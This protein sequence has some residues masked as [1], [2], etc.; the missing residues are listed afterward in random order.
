MG[1]EHIGISNPT[2]TRSKAARFGSLS[3]TPN[4]V[5]DANLSHSAEEHDV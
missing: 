1:Y 5:E 2:V 3:C 4:L